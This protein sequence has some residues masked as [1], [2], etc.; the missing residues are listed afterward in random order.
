MIAE[1]NGDMPG[2]FQ[3]EPGVLDFEPDAADQGPV[4]GGEEGDDSDDEADVGVRG[5][6][7]FSDHFS[8]RPSPQPL[9]VRILRNVVNRLFGTRAAEASGSSSS[10]EGGNVDQDGVD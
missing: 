7:E 8:E 9:P 5:V 3:G 10:S 6:E 2:Q 1:A 4:A